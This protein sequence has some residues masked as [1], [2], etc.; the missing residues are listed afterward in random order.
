[1]MKL[2]SSIVVVLVLM[3]VLASCRTG[4]SV[5]KV[6]GTCCVIDSTLDNRQDSHMVARLDSFRCEIAEEMSPVIGV[7]A[8]DIF[9]TSQ[10]HNLLANLIA[11][12]IRE[13]AERMDGQHVC[14]GLVNVGGMRRNLLKG[15]ITIGTAYELLPFTNT[16]CIMDMSGALL[17]D[18][19][20][21]IAFIGGEGLSRG[22]VL[23]ISRN[24]KLL[25]AE[26]DG[27]PIVLD[28]TYRVA[29]ID[30]LAEGNGGLYALR[31]AKNLTF[32]K[33]GLL[34]DVFI[35]KVKELTAQGKM[36]EPHR[37]LRVIVK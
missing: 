10:D 25:D 24:G 7:A 34:R 13:E 19:F 1:M 6:E 28:K 36:L 11:D 31:N 20:K 5:V 18:L 30:Y 32:P 3:S 35:R 27:A 33:D 37:D 15:P 22:V 23:T 17:V 4:Y 2:Q 26:I 9:T 8:E 14:M 21:Q 12:M 16:I 29:T